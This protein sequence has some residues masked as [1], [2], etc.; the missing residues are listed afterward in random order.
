MSEGKSV[1]L[2]KAAKELNIGI[3]TA[4]DFLVRMGHDVEAKPATKLSSDLY[5][6]LSREFQGDKI[7]KE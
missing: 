6:I 5:Q 1:T 4:V 3:A 7:I 2:L